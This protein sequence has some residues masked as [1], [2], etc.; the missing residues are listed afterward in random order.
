MIK[1]ISAKSCAD[2]KIWIQYS[3]GVEGEVD[4]SHLVVL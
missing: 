1:I 3:N 2:Y 4:L